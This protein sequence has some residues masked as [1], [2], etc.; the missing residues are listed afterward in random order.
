M[1]VSRASFPWHA[2]YLILIFLFPLFNL[3]QIGAVGYFLGGSAYA[4]RVY[5][6][7]ISHL[8]CLIK[9]KYAT[10]RLLRTSRRRFGLNARTILSAITLQTSSTRSTVCVNEGDKQAP[11]LT[12]MDIISMNRCTFRTMD[13]MLMED[14]EEKNEELNQGLSSDPLDEFLSRLV[15]YTSDNE[16]K[17]LRERGRVILLSKLAWS[18]NSC[19]LTG[20]LFMYRLTLNNGGGEHTGFIIF[21]SCCDPF[22][23]KSI[24]AKISNDCSKLLI[25]FPSHCPSAR[26][27]ETTNDDPY[28]LSCNL[29][30]NNFGVGCMVP[31]LIEADITPGLSATNTVSAPT[32]ISSQDKSRSLLH[33]ELNEKILSPK[34]R[35]TFREP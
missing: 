27:V 11:R 21:P 17:A 9:L 35:V 25:T 1:N 10:K 12:R 14:G 26:E 4:S 6:T 7:N 30:E 16:L 8:K 15:S 22:L 13:N 32:L 5:S 31:L 33:F 3:Q 19:S 18:P 20:S 23:V 2:W 34:P 29:I 28:Q 24:Y